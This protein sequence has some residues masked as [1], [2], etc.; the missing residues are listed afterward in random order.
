VGKLLEKIVHKVNKARCFAVLADETIVIAKIEQMS[1][2]LRCVDEET[3]QVREDF[4]E[5]ISVVDLTGRTLATSI[6]D[7]LKRNGICIE[8]MVGQGYD[9]AAAM[10]SD[11]CGV[12]TFVKKECPLAL[13]VHCSVHVLNLALSHSSKILPIQFCVGTVKSVEFFFIHDVWH[14]AN[15]AGNTMLYIQSLYIIILLTFLFIVFF[16]NI[17]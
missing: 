16:R 2:C 4:L 15:N 9:G 5:F 3:Y 17:F 11:I 8:F 6:I 10:M 7:C 14:D 12:H 1:L 13:Y